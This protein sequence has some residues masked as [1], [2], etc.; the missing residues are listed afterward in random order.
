MAFTQRVVPCPDEHQDCTAIDCIDASGNVVWVSHAHVDTHPECRA[1]P[2]H[3][4][5][6]GDSSV[7]MC[8]ECR[9]H[10]AP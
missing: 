8:E 5:D 10:F 3:P 4:L 2:D 1:N 6:G 7:P 9:S